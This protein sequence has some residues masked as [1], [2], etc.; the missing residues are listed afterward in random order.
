MSQIDYVYDITPTSTCGDLMYFGRFC[1]FHAISSLRRQRNQTHLK[2]R[3]LR[4]ELATCGRNKL[5]LSLIVPPDF[6]KHPFSALLDLISPTRIASHYPT[7]IGDGLIDR[8]DG[9]EFG[10]GSPNS[11]GSTEVIKDHAEGL[12]LTLPR[13]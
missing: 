5:C 12:A 6:P 10:G 7:D 13:G 11:S 3:N 4:M 9:T 1:S 8:S 2:M